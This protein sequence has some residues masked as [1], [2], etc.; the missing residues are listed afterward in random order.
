VEEAEFRA[1]CF[2]VIIQAECSCYVLGNGERGGVC[3]E[4][5]HRWDAREAA[6]KD[7]K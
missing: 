4:K 2:E 1:S 3:G 6:L 5:A 7:G